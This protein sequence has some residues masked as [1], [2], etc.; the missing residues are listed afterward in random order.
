MM[1]VKM[2]QIQERR[3][4]ASASRTGAAWKQQNLIPAIVQMIRA[5]W[6]CW[7]NVRRRSPAA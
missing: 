6:S 2:A 4:S 1:Q 7:I 3:S 5:R